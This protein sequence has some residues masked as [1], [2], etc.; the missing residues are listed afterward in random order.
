MLK[1][2]SFTLGPALT[3]AYLIADPETKEAAV[4]DPA[5]DGHE[6][7]AEAQ[8]REWRIAQM[9]YTHAHFDH[10][11]GAAGVANG[12]DPLPVVALHPGDHPLWDA[13]GGASFFGL[14]LDDPGPEPTIELYHGQTLTLGSNQFEVRH[15][16]GH[17]PGHVM[18][19]C[20]ADDVLFSGDVIFKQSIGRTDLPGGSHETL[21]N[22]IR[23][24]VLTLPDETRILSGH[25]GETTVGEERRGNPFLMSV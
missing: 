21:L 11:G 2:I 23:E 1:I 15:A 19:Y 24:Q 9:W 12:C 22:S 17:S 4:I 5:W 13:K 7:L 10:F 6:I 20:E 3:N 18:F 8:K 25:M 16:P 14:Q